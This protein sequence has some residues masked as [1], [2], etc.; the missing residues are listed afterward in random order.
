MQPTTV[1]L[2]RHTATDAE[3]GRCY[4]RQDIPLSAEGIQ[5]AETIAREFQPQSI[6]R[7]YSS[8]LRRA[9][10]TARIVAAR[11]RWT[12]DTLDGLRE[13]DFGDL[14]GLSFDEIEQR[15]PDVFK[16]WME[17]PAETRFPNGESFKRMQTRVLTA[18][19]SILERHRQESILIV[20]HTGV[21]RVILGQALGIPDGRIFRLGQQFGAI[22]RIDYF[23]EGPVV[24]LMNGAAFP[25]EK[26][27]GIPH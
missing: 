26:F 25:G 27:R 22:N 19:Q 8:T 15:F 7:V 11:E 9:S 10:E 1:W 21:I 5:H 24:Q 23:E 18:M 14:E 16:S 4:G 3:A 6:S 17:T 13:I 20:T 12:V 2:L